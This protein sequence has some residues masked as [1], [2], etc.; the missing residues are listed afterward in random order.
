MKKRITEM[1]D[2]TLYYPSSQRG[3]VAFSYM[4]DLNRNDLFMVEK[5]SENERYSPLGELSMECLNLN[6]R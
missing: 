4:L 2:S 3:Y 1:Q 6:V 5:S